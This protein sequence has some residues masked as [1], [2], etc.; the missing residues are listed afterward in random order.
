MKKIKS[1][2]IAILTVSDSRNETT[3]KSGNILKKKIN[4]SVHKVFEKK[5]CKDEKKEIE[6]TLK[7]WLKQDDLNVIIASGGT[8]LTRRDISPEV[9]KKFFEKEIP[10]FGEMFRF[11]SYKKIK[12][13]TLQTRA[14]AGTSKGKYLFL[15]PGSPSACKD[16]WD[17]IIRHQLDSSFK[18]CNLV[19]ILPKIK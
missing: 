1:L 16:A 6:L 7:H 10:G 2:N 4:N 3:D 11:L 19:E 5:I 9:F 14:C 17:Q 18:P 13:S 12:T 8:G 15:L